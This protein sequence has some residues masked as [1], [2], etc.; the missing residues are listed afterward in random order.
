MKVEWVRCEYKLPV[1]GERVLF[2]V[3]GFVGEGYVNKK[4]VWYR[5]SDYPLHLVFGSYPDKWMH[6]PNG[7]ET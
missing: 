1:A 6:L 2:H 3:D 7:G 5:F 4:G